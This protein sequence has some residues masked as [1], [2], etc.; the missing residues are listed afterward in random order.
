MSKKKKICWSCHRILIEKSVLGL[1]P[2]CVN[3]YGTAAAAVLAIP[4]GIVA[5]QAIKG[6]KTVAKGIFKI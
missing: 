4:V 6:A 5:R 1:C 3:K 2:E